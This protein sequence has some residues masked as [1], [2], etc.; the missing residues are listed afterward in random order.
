MV[1]IL[2]QKGEIQNMYI[3]GAGQ[4]INANSSH[5]RDGILKLLYAYYAW[6]L[7]YPKFYQL[8]GFFQHYV[9]GDKENQFF[10]SS[11]YLKFAKKFDS[12]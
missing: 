6:D 11:N 9:L 10:A 2:N 7:S 8:L 12:M 5:L 4:E 3:I 1:V